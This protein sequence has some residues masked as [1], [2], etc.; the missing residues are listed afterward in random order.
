MSLWNHVFYGSSPGHP[1]VPNRLVSTPL[2][3]AARLLGLK[4]LIPQH[5]GSFKVTAGFAAQAEI[6]EELARRVV[7]IEQMLKHQ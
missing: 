4:H 3:K 7:A 1:P 6:I 5:D 2:Y